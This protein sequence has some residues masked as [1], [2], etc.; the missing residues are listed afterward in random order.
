M[1]LKKKLIGVVLSLGLMSSAASISVNAV[2]TDNS[3]TMNNNSYYYSTILAQYDY[4]NTSLYLRN[5]TQSRLSSFDL[6]F[7]ST[8]LRPINSTGTLLNNTDVK[9]SGGTSATA[10]SKINASGYSNTTT[11]GYYHSFIRNTSG[12]DKSEKEWYLYFI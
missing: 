3:Y 8:E 6:L 10:I 5:Y 1:K 12:V 7:S 11:R 4:D 2:V 9:Y